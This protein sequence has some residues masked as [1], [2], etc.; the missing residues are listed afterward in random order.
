MKRPFLLK[1]LLALL[2]CGGAAVLLSSRRTVFDGPDAARDAALREIAEQCRAA[3]M[4]RALSFD[5]PFLRDWATGATVEQTET[6]AVEGVRDGARRFRPEHDSLVDPAF[7]WGSLPTNGFSFL[8]RLRLVADTR[9]RKSGSS[10]ARKSE[11]PGGR[12]S[13]SPG[14]R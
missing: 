5:G 7:M 4:V 11:S 13:G 14:G 6:E 1:T 9:V 12:K 10:G 2:L 8:L 3:G